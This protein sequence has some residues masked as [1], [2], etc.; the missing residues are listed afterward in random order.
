MKYL[1]IILLVVVI[2]SVIIF[3]IKDRRGV[4]KRTV[5]TIGDELWKEISEERE[6]SIEKGKRFRRILDQTKKKN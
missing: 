4:K 1:L 3:F 5:E 2:I 6:E